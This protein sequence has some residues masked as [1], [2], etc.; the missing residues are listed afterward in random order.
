MNKLPDFTSYGYQIVRELGKEGSIVTW[1]SI[2]IDNNIPVVIK[3][4]R[5]ATQDSNW[6]GYQAYQKEIELLKTLSHAGIPKYIADFETD[7][8][9]CLVREYIEGK[10]L[11]SQTSLT[12]TSIKIIAVKVLNILNYLQQQKPPIFYLNITPNNVLI[13]RQLNPYLIYFSLAQ[14]ANSEVD[15]S[16][17]K[18]SNAQFIAPEQVK[19]PCKAS[20]LYGLGSTLNSV[21]TKQ[22]T[23]ALVPNNNVTNS[24]S[25]IELDDGFQEWLDTMTQLELTQRYPDAETALEAL[26]TSSWEEIASLIDSDKT[27]LSNR[28]FATGIATTIVLGS[29]IS[30]GFDVSQQVTEK[31]LTNIT[32]AV[33]GMVIIYLTQSASVTLITNDNA[34]KKQGLLV[35]IAVPIL[36]TIV[37][38]IIFGSGEAVAM[39]LA[40]IIAQ[41]ATL[42]YVL[43]QKLPM[44]QQ[45]NILKAISLGSAIAIG[46]VCGTVV[47]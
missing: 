36:L 4:F 47:F 41:T 26:Q 42:A 11:A 40:A 16:L 45:G 13:D 9:F 12:E 18:T 5:F 6:S 3:Q 23:L 34:E 22:R 46:L 28:A 38:G 37:T 44:N 30:I 7:N 1:Y 10:S 2:A 15:Y 35:A 24:A 29:A 20:D 31:S 43:L 21:I 8:S 39:S 32:I 27:T 19:T 25:L 14:K 33:M 17:I